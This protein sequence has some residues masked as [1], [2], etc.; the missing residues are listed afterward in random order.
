M[1]TLTLRSMTNASD[2]RQQSPATLRNREPILAAL[3]GVLPR[4]GVVVEVASGF[5]EHAAFLAPRLPDLTWQA[6]APQPDSRQ[7]INAWID[8]LKETGQDVGNLSR[9]LELD[10]HDDP[11]PV[12]RADAIVCINMVHITAWATTQALLAGAARILSVGAPLYLY[13][14]Y[15]IDGSHTS[16]SNHAFDLDLKRRNPEWG[17][18][19]LGDVTDE[20]ARQGLMHA[21]TIAM[22]SNNFSVVFR[23]S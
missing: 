16:E 3:K 4:S 20:A 11:W 22:P 13:G 12:S 19:D 23:K 18:R 21:D 6:S 7:S 10:V 9:P 1:A 17:I 8:W 15:R 2:Q 14:P 5:G